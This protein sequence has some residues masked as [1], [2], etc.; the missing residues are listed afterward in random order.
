MSS[1]LTPYRVFSGQAGNGPRRLAIM[2]TAATLILATVGGFALVSTPT[3]PVSKAAKV[4]NAD[5]LPGGSNGSPYFNELAREQAKEQGREAE[6]AGRSYV[7]PLEGSTPPEPTPR[8]VIAD[9]VIPV[10]VPRSRPT[11]PPAVTMQANPFAP[12]ATSTPASAS[13]QRVSDTNPQPKVDEQQVAAY[14]AAMKALFTRLNGKA[15]ETKNWEKKEAAAE[16]GSQTERGGQPENGPDGLAR[17]RNVSNN[18][19][20]SIS[21]LPSSRRAG[22]VLMPADR[23]VY[24]V[25]K[26]AVSSDGGGPVIVEAQSGPIASDRMRGA[27]EQKENRLVVMLTSLTHNGRDIPIQAIVVTPDTMETTVASRVEQHYL[28]RFA[29]PAAAAFVAGLGQ[30]L[31]QSNTTSVLSPF[32]GATGFTRLNLGQQLGVAAGAS[33]AQIGQTLQQSAPKKA[34]VYLD[35]NTPVGVLFLATVEEPE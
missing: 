27:F 10:P 30:A 17:T 22:R 19:T 26:L 12:P 8:I 15:A 23:G 31:A 13:V 14:D 24:A 7:A 6:A 4:P 29:L 3:A 20:S 28:E 33:G 32:G 11:P 21:S 18:A 5:P 34:T 35:A 2:G 25:N 16:R 1:K 9:P